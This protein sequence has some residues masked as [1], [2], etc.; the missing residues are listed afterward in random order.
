M[1]SIP[2]KEVVLAHSLLAKGDWHSCLDL[3]VYGTCRQRLKHAL[4][5]FMYVHAFRNRGFHILY[6]SMPIVLNTEFL[7][8]M[9]TDVSTS[10]SISTDFLRGWYLLIVDSSVVYKIQM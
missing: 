3:G 8:K 7:Q 10:L 1:W 2:S 4:A 5:V 9:F 6:L